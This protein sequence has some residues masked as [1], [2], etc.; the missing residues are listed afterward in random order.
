MGQA[1]EI[2]IYTCKYFLKDFNFLGVRYGG[3]GVVDKFIGW[4]LY[5]G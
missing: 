4:F 5:L 1:P 3:G 2:H